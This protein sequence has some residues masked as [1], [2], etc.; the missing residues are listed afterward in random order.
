MIGYSPV[1]VLRGGKANWSLVGVGCGLVNLAISIVGTANTNLK[2][3]VNSFYKGT[4]T[5]GVDKF[6][7]FLLWIIQDWYWQFIL[8]LDKIA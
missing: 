2:N 6:D 7:L 5:S 1:T 3:A 4:T 8:K